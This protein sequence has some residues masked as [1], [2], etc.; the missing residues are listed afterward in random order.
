MIDNVLNLL[1]LPSGLK[2]VDG[3]ALP[4]CAIRPEELG[5]LL[6][7]LPRSASDHARLSGFTGEASQILLYQKEDGA[8]AGGVIGLGNRSVFSGFG[9]AA[10]A[11]PSEHVW[12]IEQDTH[13]IEAAELGFLLGAYRY[14]AH[15]TK[16]TTLSS[17]CNV[18][19][20]NRIIAGCIMF[21][22]EL[23]NT[24][25]NFLGPSELADIS[26]QLASRYGAD[27]E[28]VRGE[29]LAAR[30]PAIQAVGAGSARLPA[31]VVVKW[32]GSTVQ[33]N[34]PLISLCGKGVCFDTGG[35]NLKPGAGMRL[36]RKDMGGAAIALGIAAAIMAL[37]LPIRLE[38]RIGCAENSVSGTAMRPSD[39][40][41][42]RAGI[43]VEVGDTD[44][45]GRLILCD[46]LNEACEAKPNWLIDIATLTGAA[47]VALGPDLPALFCNDDD[48]AEAIL[49][50]GRATDDPLWRMPLYDNYS[51]WLNS[52]FADLSN[53]SSKSFG[54]AITAALFLQYFVMKPTS[55]AHIDT[56]AWND[57][58][59][60][61]KPEG[62]EAQTL[63]ALLATIE[64][65]ANN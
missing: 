12:W 30:Y 39:V 62:G 20:R 16:K 48:L 49:A 44:A 23:I 63:Q 36:M 35:Y 58:T 54:G 19:L 18:S 42:T 24:P 25:A 9:A 50:S 40:L 45:E 38:L 52:S 53:I 3:L 15:K 37:N 64:K 21:V 61:G 56:Y 57:S 28:C 4:L 34:S 22:R 51:A 60:P 47:R 46:L 55:W 17:I 2:E 27:A 29:Q 26:L 10:A 59:R 11:L 32:K 13:N 31:V 43:T 41:H 1:D 5:H 6:L 33:P 14:Q 7:K 65:L 8:L